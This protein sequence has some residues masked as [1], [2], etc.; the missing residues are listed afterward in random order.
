MDFAARKIRHV[1][2]EKRRQS[3]QDAAF[4]LATQPEQNEI[5]A[6][7]NGVDDLRNNRVIVADDAGKNW[8][9]AVLAQTR[10]EIIAQFIFHAASAQTFFRKRT[11]A[12]FAEC[13]RKTH[14]RKTPE[15]FQ[16]R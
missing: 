10:R 11:A 1:R 5:V 14:D 13:A 4:G 12:Q 9:V 6:R 15:G 7:E 3:A 8:S 16:L 2:I